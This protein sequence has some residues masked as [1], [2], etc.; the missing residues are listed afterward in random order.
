MEEFPSQARELG[1][2][3][4]AFST[5]GG[6]R[7]ILGVTDEG[8]LSGLNGLVSPQERDTM[9]RR[10]EGICHGPVKPSVTPVVRYGL[11]EGKT[12]VII[13]VPAGV[14]PVYYCNNVPYIRHLTQSRPAEPHEVVE[15]IRQWLAGTGSTDPLAY[16]IASAWAD[17]TLYADDLDDWYIKPHFDRM[18]VQLDAAARTLRAASNSD[19]ATQEGVVAELRE[20][21]VSLE[22]AVNWE[23]VMG[24]GAWDEFKSY[25]TSAGSRL[26]ELRSKFVL[27]HPTPSDLVAAATAR[28]REHTREALDLRSRMPEAI[29]GGRYDELAEELSS[30]GFR[31]YHAAAL[32][33]PE[34]ETVNSIRLAAKLLNKV[35][36]MR[37]HYSV[38]DLQT[39]IAS[40]IDDAIAQLQAALSELDRGAT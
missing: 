34:S 15:L 23:P 38:P 31:L 3:I 11:E 19:R 18:R 27:T 32:G 14:E 13:D 40:V 26:E 39:K 2:E 24:Q 35:P 17:T 7:I 22:N 16:A 5:S 8:D 37:F 12:L 20:C 10:V 21:A 29:A 33:L 6:G 4:A 25:V 1:K 9:L 28:I 36:T 30:S